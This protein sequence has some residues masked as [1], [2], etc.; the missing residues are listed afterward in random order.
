[1]KG[2]S[3]GHAQERHAG[4]GQGNDENQEMETGDEAGHGDD[5][6]EFAPIWRADRALASLARSK[7]RP[8]RPFAAPKTKGP[9]AR[10]LRKTEFE[11]LALRELERTTGLGLA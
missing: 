1:D 7:E 8:A 4:N 6:A 5:A 3:L 9:V 10:P 2:K 11:S